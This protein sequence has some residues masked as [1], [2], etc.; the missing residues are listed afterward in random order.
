MHPARLLALLVAV[1]GCGGS[2]SDSDTTDTTDTLDSD[3]AA[4]DVALTV[5]FA[6]T[7]GGEAAGCG[8]TL[9]ALGAD[10]VD[11]ELLD[12]RFYLHDVALVTPEGDV[13]VTL[14]DDGTWQSE[15]VALIDLEDGTAG[16][17]ATGNAQRNDTFTGT[18]AA[19]APTALRFTLGVPDDL[20][21]LDVAAAAPPLDVPGLYWV[22]QT[23][24][25][26]ARID[27][28]PTAADSAGWNLHLGAGGCTS[29]G[30]T[31]SP[32][33]PCARPNRPRVSV[34]IAA[35]VNADGELTLD[36]DLAL[37]A[38]FVDAP[39]GTNTMGT[40]PGCMANPGDTAECDPVFTALG[41]DWETGQCVEDCAAQQVFNLP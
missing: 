3:V 40:P 39:V 37:D 24:Y 34:P 14:D 22:W 15:A 23:G 18:A 41:L 21:H 16:C 11:S 19:T 38:L 4:T 13:P 25:K 28:R 36:V 6:A 35:A 29:S 1:A 7:Y 27:V 32:E 9:T 20:N 30:S 12:L 26:F 8:D 2:T 33:T 10:E 17:A 5:R 31:V